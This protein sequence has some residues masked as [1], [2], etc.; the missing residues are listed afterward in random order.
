MFWADARQ[1]RSQVQ[2]VLPRATVAVGNREECLVVVGAETLVTR[3]SEETP[4]ANRVR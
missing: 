4:G 2:A 3:R 1:A